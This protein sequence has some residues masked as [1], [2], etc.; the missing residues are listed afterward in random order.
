MARGFTEQIDEE[1]RRRGAMALGETYWSAVERTVRE[2]GLTD[3]KYHESDTDD[4]VDE[5][6]EYLNGRLIGFSTAITRNT[7]IADRSAASCSVLGLPIEANGTVDRTRLFLQSKALFDYGVGV[8]YALDDA[9]ELASAIEQLNSS[10]EEINAPLV[11]Q[12]ARPV[13]AMLTMSAHHP[14]ASDFIRLVSGESRSPLTTA[15]VFV[16]EALFH[17]ALGHHLHD[18]SQKNP[19]T[20]RQPNAKALIREIAAAIHRS[21]NPGILF[22]DRFDLQNANPDHPFVST[23]PCAEVAMA[24]GDACHFGYINLYALVRERQFDWTRLANSCRL[25]TRALDAIVDA[26]SKSSLNLHLVSKRRRV[27]VCI[28]GLADCL[29]SLEL[30]Y[31]SNEGRHFAQV[32]S[33]FIDFHTKLESV[34]LAE[35]RGPFPLFETSRY[36]DHAWLKRKSRYFTAEGLDWDSIYQRILTTGIRNAATTALSSAE[37]ASA[38]FGVSTS[39]EPDRFPETLPRNSLLNPAAH[40][41]RIDD[42]VS[43]AAQIEMQAA[44]QRS[45]DEAISKTITVAPETTVEEIE[46]I[47]HLAF[48]RGVLGISIYRPTHSNPVHSHG[49]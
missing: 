4:F 47:L 43:V 35:I 11:A 2:I 1:M 13:A 41:H 34:R 26:T 33:E 7:G 24:E 15:S 19:S 49:S 6:L 37:T 18:T 12:R 14:N 3:E 38:F 5:L 27:G 10:L 36:L 46:G 30:P 48:Q 32:V 29:D 8:G 40:M 31:D 9:R 45:L 42:R 39:L 44:I 16:D 22:R 20:E 17:L 23:A 25:L 21:G 28:T